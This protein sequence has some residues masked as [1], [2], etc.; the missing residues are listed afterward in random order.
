MVSFPRGLTP[1]TS[2][3]TIT[4]DSFV[5]NTTHSVT[6]TSAD[7]M[8]TTLP[9][10][11][12][13]QQYI[14]KTSLHN[15]ITNRHST[16]YQ[17]HRTWHHYTWT[18][19]GQAYKK[20]LKNFPVDASISRKLFTLYY[21]KTLWDKFRNQAWKHK[22][23][24]PRLQDAADEDP[25][26]PPMCPLCNQE[27]DSMTHLLGRCPHPVITNL[28]DKCIRDIAQEFT[29]KDRTCNYQCITQALF[30]DSRAWACLLPIDQHFPTFVQTA[31]KILQHTIPTVYSIMKTYNSI[32]HTPH[33]RAPVPPLLSLLNR[34]G[35][36]IRTRNAPVTLPAQQPRKRQP[37]PTQDIRA[38]LISTRPQHQQT[39][40]V[41]WIT[42]TKTSRRIIFTPSPDKPKHKPRRIITSPDSTDLHTH[43]THLDVEEHD[44]A[45]IIT[46][47]TPP[48][49]HPTLRSEVVF[50]EM[51]PTLQLNHIANMIDHT[52]EEVPG[53]GDCM[54]HSIKKSLNHQRM[55][56][57]LDLAPPSLR[58]SIYAYMRTP[59]GIALR[60][61]YGVLAHELHNILPTRR[62]KGDYLEYWAI[63]ALQA[64]LQIN[65]TVYFLTVRPDHRF[66]LEKHTTIIN[67]T[68]TTISILHHNR[69]HY[70][71]LFPYQPP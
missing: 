59:P 43:F 11:R 49:A 32:T 46:E 26:P 3:Y 25:L 1:P 15:Y 52:I 51:P 27:P 20:I 50:Y 28:R 37:P 8:S 62:S 63:R 21:H 65:I 4:L 23:D 70:S 34:K 36:I 7:G 9:S 71:P 61:E 67:N 47:I 64:I 5:P 30:H 6:F 66:Q 54:L 58:H 14:A 48:Q 2:K 18:A 10:S 39:P 13:I 12:A 45:D 19:S 42:P 44:I 38:F 41:H 69:N 55:N 16:Y 24:N 31:S 22:I 57:H 29:A 53:D 40:S 56:H 33:P 35:A 60:T 68:Y 17:H